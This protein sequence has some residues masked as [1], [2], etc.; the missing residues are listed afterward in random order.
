MRAVLVAEVSSEA[1]AAVQS[2]LAR[3]TCVM[4]ERDRFE[5]R[6]YGSRVSRGDEDGG[7]VVAMAAA[8]VVVGGGSGGEG[9]G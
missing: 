8:A 6:R 4:E 7:V 3:Q 9:G 2:S 5:A 1:R